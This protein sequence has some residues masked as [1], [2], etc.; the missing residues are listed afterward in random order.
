MDRPN[1]YLVFSWKTFS[2]CFIQL[3]KRETRLPISP[4][5]LIKLG[6][7]LTVVTGKARLSLLRHTVAMEQQR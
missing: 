3:S 2:F 7:C 1:K 4:T 6:T 5:S